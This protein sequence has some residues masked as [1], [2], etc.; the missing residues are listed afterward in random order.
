MG[1]SVSYKN[2]TIGSIFQVFCTVEEGSFPVFF[3]WFR[4][5][6]TLNSSPEVNY[7]IENSRI[8]S[9]LTIEKI[10]RSD[11]GNYTCVVK[12]PF[13]SDAQNVVLIKGMFCINVN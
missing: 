6:K 3:E 9:T 11:Q 1:Y 2:Q 13:G 4:N 12:N 7:R 8:S 10:A 5:S